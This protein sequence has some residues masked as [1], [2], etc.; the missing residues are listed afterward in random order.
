MRDYSKGII[1]SYAFL[2]TTVAHIYYRS[3][4]DAHCRE[5]KPDLTLLWGKT[6][7]PQY[8]RLYTPLTDLSSTPSSEQVESRLLEYYSY[9]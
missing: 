2:N 3:L 6:H 7:T 5:D 9:S 4:N 8:E 1:S